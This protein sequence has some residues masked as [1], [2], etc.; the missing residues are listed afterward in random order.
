MIFSGLTLGLLFCYAN[1]WFVQHLV[2]RLHVRL[3]SLLLLLRNCKNILNR[4]IRCNPVSSS[5]SNVDRVSKPAY[6][7]VSS[8][9]SVTNISKSLKFT[10]TNSH[11]IDS[12]TST[13]HAV[14]H[15]NIH[16]KRK[17][18]KSVISSSFVNSANG[19]DTANK[20]IVGRDRV[21]VLT[22]PG[23]Y[24]I[25]LVFFLS[26]LFWEFLMLEIFI[27]NN[28][29]L[30]SNSKYIF[31]DTDFTHNP[32]FVFG[33]NYLQTNFSNVFNNF[34]SFKSYNIFENFV[35]FFSCWFYYLN[36]VYFISWILRN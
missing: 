35:N 23:N 31:K 34:Y 14:S 11:S 18:L 4:S 22:K 13:F 28:S 29:F 9:D 20:L 16:R 8:S 19:Y 24:Y 15:C 10:S 32:P 12:S 21:N 25:S 17:L 7:V 36:L 3:L 6:P 26:A 33:T 5:S 27:N 30:E 2:H 1:L